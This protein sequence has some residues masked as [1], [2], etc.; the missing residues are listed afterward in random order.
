[1]STTTAPRTRKPYLLG[2]PIHKIQTREVDG[3]RTV[4]VRHDFLALTSD[5]F[6]LLL[7][8]E[9]ETVRYQ[10]DIGKD[11]KRAHGDTQYKGDLNLYREIITGGG[12]RPDGLEPVADPSS[13]GPEVRG[14]YKEKDEETGL[15]HPDWFTFTREQALKFTAERTKNAIE[16]YLE[17][18]G[19]HVSTSTGIDF[20]FEQGGTIRTRLLIGDPLQPAYRLLFDLHRPE[21][22]RRGQF[23]DNFA[24]GV[25]TR[26]GDLPRYDTIIDL[27]QGKNVFDEFFAEP[28]DDPDHDYVV[29]EDKR[30]PQEMVS[31]GVQP[32]SITADEDEFRVRPYDAS[33]KGELLR[34]LHPMYKVELAATMIGSFSKTDRE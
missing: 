2:Q 33:L 3:D 14:L 13:V 27:R 21:S 15:W 34:L 5:N 31:D 4:I 19:E 8:R 1:M 12:W 16:R 6:K 17:C 11:R 25:E 23:R 28:V 32:P 24:Y 7:N 20:M 10:E 18:K 29:F 30:T 22:T 26:K 9:E